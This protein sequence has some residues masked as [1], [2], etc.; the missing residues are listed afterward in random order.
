M[1]FHAENIPEVKVRQGALQVIESGHMLFIAV[2]LQLE[3]TP[4]CMRSTLLA[5][6]YSPGCI[7]ML[8]LDLRHFTAETPRG[9]AGHQSVIL[10]LM[11]RAVGMAPTSSWGYLYNPGMA[12]Y[13]TGM[14]AING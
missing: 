3:A 7:I 1:C 12:G 5:S 14:R 13:S 8:D 4:I 10:R 11:R 9:L 2:S 6:Q